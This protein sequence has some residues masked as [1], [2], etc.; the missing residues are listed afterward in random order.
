MKVIRNCIEYCGIA[1]YI[2][3]DVLGFDDFIIE[4]IV[5]IIDKPKIKYFTKCKTEQ[6][7]FKTEIVDLNSLDGKF[8]MKIEG[9]LNSL[10][11]YI[12]LE[13]N[14]LICTDRK[15]FNFNVV[16]EG[17]RVDKYK[18]IISNIFIEDIYLKK[19]NEKKY[20]ISFSILGVVEE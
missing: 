7:I 1:D 10:I 12:S 19:I 13:Y 11:E 15:K 3:C 8:K 9:S 4:E 17:Q 6:S 5:E 18:K 2:P 20:I 16:V 14:N